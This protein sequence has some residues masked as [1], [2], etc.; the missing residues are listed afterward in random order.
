MSQITDEDDEFLYGSSE[1]EP[2]PT[3]NN[4]ELKSGE[5]HCRD[6]AYFFMLKNTF[7]DV[8]DLYDL[9]EDTDTKE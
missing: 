2:K 7:I 3:A 5:L 1:M 6:Y 8:D 9:Y 4:L